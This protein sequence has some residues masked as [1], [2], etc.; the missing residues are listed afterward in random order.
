M[1]LFSKRSQKTSKC[2]KNIR[3]KLGYRLVCHLFC[4]YHRITATWNL[5]VN[6]TRR[7]FLDGQREERFWAKMSILASQ[8]AF[9]YWTT[10]SHFV[11]TIC[12]WLE[13]LAR[14]P[15]AI[16]GKTNPIVTCTNAFSRV[17]LFPPLVAVAV[18]FLC[19][20]IGSFDQVCLL[21]L[22]KGITS[23]LALRN[24]IENFSLC[25]TEGH[26]QRGC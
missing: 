24:L 10:C 12:D 1:R 20:P 4:S 25:F 13:N 7:V 16:G 8:R 11:F 6:S 26:G 14:H 19:V 21:R 15:L 2:G 3:D 9:T 23:V 18:Y 22:A 5:F 17:R